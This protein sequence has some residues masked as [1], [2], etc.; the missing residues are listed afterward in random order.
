MSDDQRRE[1]AGVTT[2]LVV[3]YIRDVLGEDAVDDLLRR[4]GETRPVSVLEDERTWSTYDQKIALFTAAAEL[5]GDP[6]AAYRI[7]SYVLDAQLARSQ[8]MALAALGSPQQLLKSI[9]R[10]NVKFSTSATMRTV[11]TSRGHGTV[12]YC[13]PSTPRAGTTATTTRG[14]S[15]GS[16]CCSACPRLGSSTRP[17]RWTGTRSASTPCGGPPCAGWLPGRAAGRGAT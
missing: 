16:P 9:A 10:A 11:E 3:A 12:A 2:R 13:T 1:T 4:S 5:T 14:S 7:G 8:R 6:R 17:A 15:R